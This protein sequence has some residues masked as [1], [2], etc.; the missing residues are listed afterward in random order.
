[1]HFEWKNYVVDNPHET[2]NTMYIQKSMKKYFVEN[3]S[4]QVLNI[5]AEK[6]DSVKKILVGILIIF[7]ECILYLHQ[8][9]K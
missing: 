8:N 2:F 6:I 5:K 4:R 1:M 7:L 3:L 9:P